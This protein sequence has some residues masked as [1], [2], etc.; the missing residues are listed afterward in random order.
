MMQDSNGNPLDIE[1][2]RQ[3]AYAQGWAAAAN[4]MRH[5]GT[6][7]ASDTIPTDPLIAA[8][9]VGLV[10]QGGP[11]G[12]DTQI[13]YNNNGA[14]G[15]TAGMTWNPA[16]PPNTPTSLQLVNK[17]NDEALDLD[18]R[19]LI[20][21]ENSDT[22]HSAHLAGSRPILPEER[23]EGPMRPRQWYRWEITSGH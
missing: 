16:I 9:R 7:E 20:S 10:M 4:K 2:V 1:A 12:S 13:Q 8:A 15:G 14:F 18:P 17:V 19:G 22:D 5:A 11:G 21:I 23:A 3:E 6:A